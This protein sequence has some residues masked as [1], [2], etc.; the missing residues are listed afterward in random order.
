M[1]RK[2]RL[3]L[4]LA[5]ILALFASVVY[6]QQGEPTPR[7]TPTNVPPGESGSPPPAVQ[8]DETKGS[9]R[10]T[11]YDDKNADGSCSEDPVL[12]GVPIKFVSNDLDTTVYLQSGDNGTYGLVAAGLGTWMVSAEPGAG[13]IVTSKNPL[14]VFIDQGSR[15]AT[16]VNFCVAK[17]STTGNSGTGS[18]ILPTAGSA[19][20][21]TFI[22]VSLFGLG[23]VL[24]G[25]GIEW[26]RRRCA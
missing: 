2:V 23:L 25:A 24:A 16:G 12:V 3:S 1:S 15:L 9:I 13:M 6:A 14:Q 11:V 10:G 20:A 21:P 8:G 26:R 18:V 19:V 7:P 22:V 17:G 5:M 4:S